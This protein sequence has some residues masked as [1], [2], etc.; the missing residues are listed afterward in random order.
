[1]ITITPK[2]SLQTFNT[3]VTSIKESITDYP[4]SRYV[5]VNKSDYV[6]IIASSTGNQGSELYAAKLVSLPK[7][8]ADTMVLTDFRSYG[9]SVSCRADTYVSC[10]TDAD[11]S[12][13]KL[14]FQE[15]KAE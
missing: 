13:I 5:V 11:Q 10:Y 9:S 1:M 8:D 15:L 7:I 4:E 3:T 2:D 12:E 6:A 14:F